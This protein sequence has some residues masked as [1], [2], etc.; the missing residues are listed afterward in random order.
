MREWWV[1]A[2]LVLS[3]PRAVFVALR[4]DDPDDLTARSEPVL[5]IVF[6]AGIAFVLATPTASH[7]MDD[8]DYDGTLVAVWSFL[9]GG[10]Y[11][12][13]AYWLLGAVLFGASSA[14]GSEGTYRRSRHV[15]A[16][17]AVPVIL[18]L[19]VWPVK[20][21][22]YGSDLF[23]RGGSD[24]GTGTDVFDAIFLGA[25]AWSAALLVIGVRSVHGWAW[26]KALV[27]AAVPV[28][29]GAAIALV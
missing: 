1:R 6:L 29:M 25:C 14:L 7:L 24:S 8:N 23:H 21:A 20:L 16:F 9:A 27:A 28:A 4:R 26:P 22:L 2:V 15:L 19:A 12:T 13:L 17:A 3:A 18:T 10:L 5:A 11:G